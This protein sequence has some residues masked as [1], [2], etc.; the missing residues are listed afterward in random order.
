MNTEILLDM[1]RNE[2]RLAVEKHPFF[3]H[4]IIDDS[5]RTNAEYNLSNFRNCLRRDT[6]NGKISSMAVLVCEVFEFV[7]AYSDGDLDHALVEL[8][9]CGAVIMRMM[10]MVEKESEGTK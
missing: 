1:I 8:A 6:E 4:E 9:Q 3:A 7:Q 2:H 5:D 10:E